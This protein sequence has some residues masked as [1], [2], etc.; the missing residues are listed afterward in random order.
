M[1]FSFSANASKRI[2]LSALLFIGFTGFS[3][4][5]DLV[6]SPSNGTLT[7]FKTFTVDVLVTNNTESINAVSGSFTY[8]AETLELLSLS[9]TGSIINLWAE[10]PTSGNGKGSF[11]GVILNP[12]F[13]GR[14]GKAL[15]LT[16]RAK[17][18]GTGNVVFTSGSVLAND[19]NATDV[20]HT[21]GSATY[22]IVAGDTVKAL[23]IKEKNAPVETGTPTS[24]LI[25][26]SESYPNE[27]A[28]YSTR[29]A[30]FSWGLP[31]NVTAVRTLYSDDLASIPDK[32]Y[33]PPISSKSFTVDTDGIYYMHVQWK[34]GDAWGQ[35][36]HRKFQIDT[37]SPSITKI[38]LA[39]ADGITRDATPVILIEAEDKT[40]GI[41]HFDFS[42]DG[43]IARRVPFST[44]SH[45]ELEKLPSG[46]HTLAVTAYDKAGNKAKSSYDFIEEVLDAPTIISYTKHAEYGAPVEISG[47][48]YPNKTVE[49]A[50]I[51]E[52]GDV[53][54]KTTI[55]NEDGIF[56]YTWK[57]SLRSGV[58]EFRARVL[59]QSGLASDYSDMRTILIDSMKLIKVGMFV[60]NWL[61]LLLIII[62]ASAL[63]AA[64][65]W[66][67]ILQVSRFKRGVR[68][69]IQEVEHALTASALALRRDVESFHTILAKA[70]KKRELTKEEEAIMKKFKKHLDQEID[71]KLEE[72]R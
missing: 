27:D 48:T 35:I 11:E 69:A 1:P 10:E 20:L 21:L 60:M 22:V 37:E 12:G 39:E 70:K 6:F 55:S 58:Y 36:A 47:K 30:S 64:T 57:D 31:D 17:A 51:H 32:I 9:K 15:T 54:T 23:P 68:R 67:S 40:S 4:A 53:N 2:V 71:K 66:Y 33:N 8:T 65:S 43:K 56:S 7:A 34:I 45:Y 46:S 63:V 72:I 16:F 19:G 38:A 24:S 28:W 41:D 5:A 52:N 3:S 49:I 42:V 18:E 13:D 14:T 26:R 25:I 61:S 50:L 29:K 44:S 62:L 59:D